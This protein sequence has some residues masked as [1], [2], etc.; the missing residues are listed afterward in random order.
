MYFSLFPNI[1]YKFS[2][3][4]TAR[5]VTD[6]IKRVKVRDT[7]LT[8][9][10]LYDL[11]FVKDGETPHVLAAKY[12]NNPE[13]H[14]IL[15]LTNTMIDPMFDWPMHSIILNRFIENKY[16]ATKYDV[17][18]Y[19][20]VSPF[21]W[22]NGMTMPHDPDFGPDY[23]ADLYEP[24]IEEIIPITNTE[25]EE[26]KNDLARQINLFKPELVP[27]MIQEFTTLIQR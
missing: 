23:G 18:H 10:T 3:E 7:I 14:W 9:A 11:Y 24:A 2:G 1:I 4:N 15:M 13:L 5:L 19:Q 20:L 17:H 27:Q 12:Y 25:Y 22:R 16:G 26:H 8:T 6:I 21:E